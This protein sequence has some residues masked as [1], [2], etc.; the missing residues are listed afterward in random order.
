MV[1]WIEN[2]I[3]LFK[4]SAEV[5]GEMLL[6]AGAEDIRKIQTP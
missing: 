3:R 1:T 4:Y 6:A 5:G 2:E